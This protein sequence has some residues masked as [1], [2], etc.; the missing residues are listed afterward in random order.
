MFEGHNVSSTC[1]VLYLLC[2]VFNT[3]IL[4]IN[5]T[6]LFYKSGV[7]MYGNDSCEEDIK[8]TRPCRAL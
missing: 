1:E 2:E 3:K 4:K 8:V 5:G 6:G 7:C